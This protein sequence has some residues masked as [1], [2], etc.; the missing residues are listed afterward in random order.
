MVFAKSYCPFCK[1]TKGLLMQ[2][3]EYIEV[4]VEFIDL[5]DLPG[6]DGP[7]IQ[8]QLLEITGQRTVPNIFIGQQHVG[9]N[10]ELQQL[11]ALGKLE[12]MLLEASGA[13]EL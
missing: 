12:V 4:G 6:D 11:H 1:K 2:L 3:E 10:S 13:P 7:M 8:Q 9:G 5:D